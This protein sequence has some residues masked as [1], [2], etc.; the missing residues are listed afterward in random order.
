MGS[1][2]LVDTSVLVELLDI[3]GRNNRHEEAKQ[4]YK[5]LEKNGDS[6]VLPMAAIL[7]TGNHIAHISDGC[8][9][10]LMIRICPDMNVR[11]GYQGAEIDKTG[12]YINESSLQSEVFRPQV[13]FV[14]MLLGSLLG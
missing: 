3:P 13:F 14:S 2:H 1:V 12:E 5:E 10:G 4:E 9:S 6:F 7:E 8:G 11:E